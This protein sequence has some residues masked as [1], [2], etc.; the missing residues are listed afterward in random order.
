MQNIFKLDIVLYSWDQRV[1]KYLRVCE[2]IRIFES[3]NKVSGTY[4]KLIY[5]LARSSQG[6]NQLRMTLKK[7]FNLF[8]Q[9]FPHFHSSYHAYQ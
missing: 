6:A 4:K 3:L 1:F 9:F 8:Q 7:N 5:E 2:Y